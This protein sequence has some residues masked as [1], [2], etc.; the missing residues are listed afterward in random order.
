M[1]VIGIAGASGCGKTTLAEAVAKKFPNDILILHHDN[2]YR[3]NDH[4][5]MEERRKINFDHPDSLETE[6]LVSDLRKL[7]RGETVIG[8]TYDFAACTRS[9]VT[10]TL[11]PCP[12]VIVEGILI[13]ENQQ[14]LDEIDVKIF[15][16]VDADVALARRT[17]R[18]CQP[19][20]KHGRGY[21]L[22]SSLDAYMS[23][24]KPMFEKY[25]A[26][27]RKKADIIVSGGANPVACE[28]LCALAEKEI[29]KK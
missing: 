27:T 13:Y 15:R 5:P 26:P 2:Y 8:P 14:L 9:K 21:T 22:E 28:M 10:R 25:V 12:V 24:V 6:L 3:C 20:E 4:L 11:N 1:L 23:R 7:K 17:L 18:D 29:A 19:P 16:D